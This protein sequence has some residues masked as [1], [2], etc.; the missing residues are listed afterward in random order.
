MK[1][2]W[3]ELYLWRCR[4]KIIFEDHNATVHS[5][6]PWCSCFPRYPKIPEHKVQCA[7]RI[8]LRVSYKPK[9]MIF[10]PSFPFFREARL[11]YTCHDIYLSN[12]V[13]YLKY[14]NVSIYLLY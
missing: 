9:W 5:S 14:L 1:Q 2:W 11:S 4:W 12:I 3:P 6:F 7:V 8:F 10:A 13:L